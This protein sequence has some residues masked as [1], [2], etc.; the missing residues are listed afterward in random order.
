MHYSKHL[1]EMRI[2]SGSEQEAI[3]GGIKNV[4]YVFDRQ[5]LEGG[6]AFGNSG[7]TLEIAADLVTFVSFIRLLF[8]AGGGF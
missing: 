3:V 2:L 6:G 4:E 1:P 5:T 7:A 8:E